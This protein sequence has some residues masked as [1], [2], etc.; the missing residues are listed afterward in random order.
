M[1]AFLVFFETVPT[2]I[3]RALHSFMEHLVSN[4]Y[5]AIQAIAIV[6]SAEGTILD[7]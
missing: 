6:Y 7:I 4:N 5:K 2:N 1:W 3:I